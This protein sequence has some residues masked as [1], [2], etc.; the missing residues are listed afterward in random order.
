M[1]SPSHPSSRGH[2]NYTWRRTKDM[3]LLRNVNKQIKIKVR[4]LMMMFTS[5]DNLAVTYA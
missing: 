2:S 5:D 1:P 4:W 3:K